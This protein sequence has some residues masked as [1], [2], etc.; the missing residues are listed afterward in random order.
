MGVLSRRGRP[1]RPRGGSTDGKSKLDV[2]K[3]LHQDSRLGASTDTT[4]AV[5]VGLTYAQLADGRSA[6]R[7]AAEAQNHILYFTATYSSV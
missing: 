5:C 7:Q 6:R 3:A 1:S 2:G 4:D